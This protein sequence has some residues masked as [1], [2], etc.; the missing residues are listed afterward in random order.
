MF[1]YWEGETGDGS[2]AEPY[3]DGEGWVVA[4]PHCPRTIDLDGP[5]TPPHIGC[6]DDTYTGECDRCHTEVE[7][8]IYLSFDVDRAKVTKKAHELLV[9]DQDYL[10]GLDHAP[11]IWE[12]NWITEWM[13]NDRAYEIHADGATWGP[14]DAHHYENIHQFCKR[15]FPRKASSEA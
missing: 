4:C 11:T 3:H 12:R 9:D 6:G 2:K 14:G 1:G 15:V 13:E 8:G 7:V 5:D 10:I